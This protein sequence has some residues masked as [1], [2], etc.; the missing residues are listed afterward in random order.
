MEDWSKQQD[1]AMTLMGE[2]RRKASEYKQLNLFA[3]SY[4]CTQAAKYLEQFAIKCGKISILERQALEKKDANAYVD[5]Q[6]I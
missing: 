6:D 5:N 2:C 4:E 3:L 1:R